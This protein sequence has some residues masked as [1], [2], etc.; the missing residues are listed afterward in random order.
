M[1]IQNIEYEDLIFM[2]KVYMKM[3]QNFNHFEATPVFIM[4]NYK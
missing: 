4:Y 1:D 2:L 3:S